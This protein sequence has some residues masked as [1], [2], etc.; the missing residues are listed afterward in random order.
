M[1]DCMQN[2]WYNPAAQ[3]SPSFSAAK[4][5][6]RCKASIAGMLEAAPEEILFTSGATESNNQV[7]RAF[8]GK[9]VLLSALE[10]KSVLESARAAGCKIALLYPD[11]NGVIDPEKAK[12]AMTWDTALVSILYASNETGVIQPVSEIAA[13]AKDMHIPFHTD[14]VQA[15]G[16]IPVCARGFDFLTFTGHKLYGPKG[17][18]GLYMRL[19]HELPPL[20]QGGGQQQKRRSGTED[21]ALCAGLEKACTLAGADM[22]QRA[23]RERALRDAFEALITEKIK[24]ARVLGKDVPRVPGISAILLP[25]KTAN[26]MVVRLNAK[27]ILISGGA[28]CDAAS[29][30]AM[31]GYTAMGLTPDE[32]KRVIRVSIGRH[33]TDEELCLAAREI[34]RICT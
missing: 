9:R 15:F 34:I 14:A 32:A 25:G 19:G 3:Y 20:I 5:I 27:G 24:G 2:L 10:H 33:T 13:L 11:K 8:A 26:E 23:Q 31:N 17:I 7:L 30:G 29:A 21:T 16:H 4:R 28:A 22:A 12:E 6:A 1:A 18:G